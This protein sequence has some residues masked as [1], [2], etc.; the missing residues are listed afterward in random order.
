M[1]SIFSIGDVQAMERRKSSRRQE[2]RLVAD[3]RRASFRVATEPVQVRLPFPPMMNHYYRTAVVARHAQTYISKDGKAYRD[4][5]IA[6]WR[7]VGVTFEGRLA[8]R[9]EAVFPNAMRRDL[10]GILKA[11]LD[12]LEHAG[13]YA[14]DS[15]V[16]LLIVEQERTEMPGWVEVTIGPKPGERQG[17][18]F[19]TA[20]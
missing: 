11:L 14:N 13:A 6:A 3:N 17:S 12:S 18:L 7:K 16:K 19:G 20:W 2:E 4:E 9:V 10:D 1:A 15:Q 8:V 5:V